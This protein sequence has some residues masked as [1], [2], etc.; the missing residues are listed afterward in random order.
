MDPKRTK[1]GPWGIKYAFI[2][3]T[4]N[5]KAHILLNLE[6]NVI[7]KFWDVE[8]FE[9][10]ITKD[11]DSKIPTNEESRDEESPRIVEYN[12]KVFHGLLK[13]NLSVG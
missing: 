4:F 7:V 9:N 1:L 2:G 13:H 8:F 11:K 10:L 6:S 3:Y 12:L 5:N